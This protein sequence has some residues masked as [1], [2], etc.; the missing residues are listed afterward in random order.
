MHAA[1]IPPIL[2]SP[3]GTAAKGVENSLPTGSQEHGS[4]G[5]GAN[6]TAQRQAKEST[7]GLASL[8][9]LGGVSALDTPREL[10]GVSTGEFARGSG[11]RSAMGRTE[12]A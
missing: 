12:L 3:P 2:P 11:I 7:D 6:G 5:Y 10:S 4:T 1:N 9:E 8:Y